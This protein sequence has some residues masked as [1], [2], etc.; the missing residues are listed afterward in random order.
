[1]PARI[2]VGV[3]GTIGGLGNKHGLCPHIRREEVP[4]SG[5]LAFVSEIEP[6]AREDGRKLALI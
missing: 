2:Q 5:Q 6:A 1:M 3:N 4:W